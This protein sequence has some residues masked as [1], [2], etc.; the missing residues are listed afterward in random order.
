VVDVKLHRA[1][2]DEKRSGNFRIPHPMRDKL[3]HF[4]L[5]LGQI[6]P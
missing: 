5:P 4:L 1:L 3:Q 2:R 6:V